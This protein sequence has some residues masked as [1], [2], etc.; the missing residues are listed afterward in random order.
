MGENRSGELGRMCTTAQVGEDRAEP[1]W[2]RRGL[3]LTNGSPKLAVDSW[4]SLA[5][6]EP[7]TNGV[8]SR[9]SIL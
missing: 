6:L 1:R 9:Y 7:R 5:G 3:V 8:G 4:A 2:E